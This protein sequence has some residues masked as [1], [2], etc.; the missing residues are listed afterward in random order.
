MDECTAIVLDR[1][2]FQF[3]GG[4]CPQRYGVVGLNWNF[5]A[6]SCYL[7]H[8]HVFQ[9]NF[10]ELQLS[11]RARIL[12]RH[13]TSNQPALQPAFQPAFQLHGHRPIDLS[14]H[15]PVLGEPFCLLALQAS[16]FAV[17]ST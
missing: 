15:N 1:V 5:V 8:P 16:R 7:V 6:W 3:S 12:I 13:S 2:N 11:L 10:G 17:V 9:S 4:C 14:V